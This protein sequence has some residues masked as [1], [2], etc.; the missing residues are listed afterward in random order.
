MKHEP[1]SLLERV[2]WLFPIRGRWLR[3]GVATGLILVGMFVIQVAGSRFD[4]PEALPG[5]IALAGGAL[6]MIGFLL[7]V[8]TLDQR[9]GD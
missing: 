1:K 9:R 8:A 5:L 4:M 7:L 3:H 2:E 6:F